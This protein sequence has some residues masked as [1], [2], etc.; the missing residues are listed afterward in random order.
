MLIIEVHN[1]D[2]IDRFVRDRSVL[3]HCIDE[4]EYVYVHMVCVC[5][6]VCVCVNP[7][8]LHVYGFHLCLSP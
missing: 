7:S 2:I 6:C 3:L 8:F 5:V 4:Q 1:R